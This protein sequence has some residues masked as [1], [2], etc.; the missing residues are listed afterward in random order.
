MTPAQP[1]PAVVVEG[2]LVPVD[3]AEETQCESCQ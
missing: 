1:E 3:P 2:Y